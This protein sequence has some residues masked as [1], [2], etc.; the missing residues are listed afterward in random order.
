MGMLSKKSITVYPSSKHPE[1]KEEILRVFK[2]MPKWIPAKN[3]KGE[4]ICVKYR[5]PVTFKLK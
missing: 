3:Y 1:F 5:I 2:L 4:P